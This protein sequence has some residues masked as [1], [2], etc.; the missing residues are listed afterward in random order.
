MSRTFLDIFRTSWQDTLSNIASANKK[1]TQASTDKIAKD[2]SY[3]NSGITDDARYRFRRKLPD[4]A[5]KVY[6]EDFLTRHNGVDFAVLN[7]QIR[8]DQFPQTNTT[9][10]PGSWGHINH[11]IALFG[12]FPADS[13]ARQSTIEYFRNNP[14]VA[15]HLDN[16]TSM[17]RCLLVAGRLDSM[18]PLGTDISFSCSNT[19]VI[20]DHDTALLQLRRR[21]KTS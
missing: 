4:Q 13:K 10:T 2:K 14:D 1:F 16:M 9:Y 3:K 6:V 8:D 7:K 5:D 12:S 20:K 18:A 19:N 21:V 17:Q 15:K 11:D